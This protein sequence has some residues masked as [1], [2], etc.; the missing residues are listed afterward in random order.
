M[1]T[2]YVTFVCVCLI[3]CVWTY[4]LTLSHVLGYRQLLL[5]GESLS[6]LLVLV[7]EHSLLIVRA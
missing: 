5:L 4:V 3:S 7:D 6:V 2:V 1:C